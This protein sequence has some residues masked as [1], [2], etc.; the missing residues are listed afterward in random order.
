MV[1][2]WFVYIHKDNRDVVSIILS[3]G[4]NV[5]GKDTVYYKDKED[6]VEIGRTKFKHGQFQTGSFF[7]RS[8]SW[9][10]RLDMATWYFFVLPE[11][12]KFYFNHFKN[13]RHNKTLFANSNV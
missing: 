4:N 2:G 5:D 13:H 8:L 10:R 9:K 7:S 12:N 1:N 11:K 6:T 3:L